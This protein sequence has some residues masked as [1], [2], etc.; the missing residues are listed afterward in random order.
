ML[1]YFVLFFIL[2]GTSSYAQKSNLLNNT[3]QQKLIAD[4]NLSDAIYLHPNPVNEFL[5]IKSQ[6]FTITKIEIFSIL[7]GKL[8]EIDPKTKSIYL[9]DLPRGIY[10]I[11]IY[12]K[13]GYTVKK[14]IKK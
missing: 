6:G 13:K 7:G 10:L 11:K 5:K 2:I 12:S 3:S 9:G 8:K 4:E 1:K 14:L